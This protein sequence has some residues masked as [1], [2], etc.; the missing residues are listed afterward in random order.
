VFKS[1]QR[2]GRKT[3]SAATSPYELS[4][5]M[6]LQSLH[7]LAYGGSSDVQFLGRS[8]EALVPRNNL[9]GTQ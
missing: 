4:T 3:V 6:I 5:Q 9:E 8:T 2:I 7:L 1:G